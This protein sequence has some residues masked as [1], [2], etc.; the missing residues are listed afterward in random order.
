VLLWSTPNTRGALSINILLLWR[1]RR[2]IKHVSTNIRMKE[3]VF[4]APEG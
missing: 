1:R 3:D 2:R 4:F